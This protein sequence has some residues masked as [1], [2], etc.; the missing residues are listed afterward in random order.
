MKITLENECGIY[1]VETKDEF[2][3]INEYFTN[4]I[5][6]VLLAGG[7]APSTIKQALEEDY[8]L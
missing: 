5:V 2:A 7:F 3:H 4:L 1:S 6:P 8:G